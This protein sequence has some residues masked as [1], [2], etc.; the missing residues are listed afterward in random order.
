R[1]A[2]GAL[3]EAGKYVSQGDGI[4]VDLDLEIFFDRVNHDI[5]LARLARRIGD[6][7]ILR[8]IRRFL[9]AGMM[10]EGVCVRR[11]EGTPQ[12]GPVSPLLAIVLLDDLDKMLEARGHRLCRY[13]VGVNI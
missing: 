3:A 13:A 9:E 11:Q 2:H 4:V 8:I 7:R 12:G 10:A 6:E 5:L 1:S